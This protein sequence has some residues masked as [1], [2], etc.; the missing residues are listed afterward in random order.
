MSVAFAG[1]VGS[2]LV[3]SA[4]ASVDSAQFAELSCL[5]LLD[6]AAVQHN[7]QLWTINDKSYHGKNAFKHRRIRS[8]NKTARHDY[9]D[10]FLLGKTYDVGFQGR[11]IQ[12]PEDLGQTTIELL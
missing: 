11:E 8:H 7:K 4:A 1:S 9:K 2:R 10:E 3:D 5:F 12:F 6:C